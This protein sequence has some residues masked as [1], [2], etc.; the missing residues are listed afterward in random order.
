MLVP[1]NQTAGQ[2]HQKDRQKYIQNFVKLKYKETKN[3]NLAYILEI[4]SRSN[5]AIYLFTN[6]NTDIYKA[7]VLPAVRM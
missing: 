1:H 4:K 6:L 7:T 2:N 5:S 3:Y